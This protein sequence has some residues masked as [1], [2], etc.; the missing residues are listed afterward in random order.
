VITIFAILLFGSVIV[1]ADRDNEMAPWNQLIKVLVTNEEPID[2]TIDGEVTL[3][4]EELTVKDYTGSPI[5][6]DVQNEIEFSGAVSLAENTEVG[7]EPG[8]E[9][10]LEPG[11][12]VVIVT[13]TLY[14]IVLD[15]VEFPSKGAFSTEILLDGYKTL[16]AYIEVFDESSQVNLYWMYKTPSRDTWIPFE[17]ISTNGIYTYEIKAPYLAIEALNFGDD[18]SFIS[19]IIYAQRV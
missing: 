6:V 10:G 9:V 13:D 7:L 3:S 19:V 17:G 18:I 1:S 5:A 14:H 2:V 12:E 16:H 15:S 11:A 8:T 4:S